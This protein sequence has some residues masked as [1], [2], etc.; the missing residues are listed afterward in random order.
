L[1]EP[2]LDKELA[3]KYA[4]KNSMTIVGI[5]LRGGGYC[6]GGTSSFL[7]QGYRMNIRTRTSDRWWATCETPVLAVHPRSQ[8]REAG[9]RC[10]RTAP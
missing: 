2:A 5:G 7:D 1:A 10:V 6:G 8:Y 4:V 9:F 3:E